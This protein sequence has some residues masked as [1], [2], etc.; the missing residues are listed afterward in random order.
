MSEEYYAK[1]ST[2]KSDQIIAE[3]DAIIR[4]SIESGGEITPEFLM[5]I[6]SK[7]A[8]QNVNKDGLGTV[9]FSNIEGGPFAAILVRYEGAFLT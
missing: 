5:G 3:A 9:N 1:Y 7:I 8:L 6:A 2:G 4:K